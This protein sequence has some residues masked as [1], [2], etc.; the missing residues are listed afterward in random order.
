[1]IG[2]MLMNG[3]HS[4]LKDFRQKLLATKRGDPPTSRAPLSVISKP[5]ARSCEARESALVN[6]LVFINDIF[7][8]HIGDLHFADLIIR[9]SRLH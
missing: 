2:N 4:L 9:E 7:G 5:C 6:V 3:Q 8:Y 1:M